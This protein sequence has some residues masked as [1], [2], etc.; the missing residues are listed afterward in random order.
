MERDAKKIFH[1]M[2]EKEDAMEKSSG[3]CPN[4]A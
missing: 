4:T 3:A 2:L 1:E